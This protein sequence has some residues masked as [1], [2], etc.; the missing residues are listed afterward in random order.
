[1]GWAANGTSKFDPDGMPAHCAAEDVE[2]FVRVNLIDAREMNT[3][4]HRDAEP[5]EDPPQW[6]ANAEVTEVF[7]YLASDESRAV[8]GKRFQA[9]EENWG[10]DEA[11]KA[12]SNDE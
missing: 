5:D 4:M 6:A 1:P 3:K 2:T 7:I 9:Q 11:A 10:Q 8:N 12:A